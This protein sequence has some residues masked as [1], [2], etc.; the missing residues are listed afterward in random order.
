V[1]NSSWKPA[2]PGHSKRIHS[3]TQNISILILSCHWGQGLWTSVLVNNLWRDFSRSKRTYNSLPLL[4]SYHKM[5]HLHVLFFGVKLIN[6]K[7]YIINLCSTCPDSRSS[8]GRHLHFL[9]LRH[10]APLQRPYLL[11]GRH[12]V[13]TRTTE[14]VEWPHFLLTSLTSWL[15][16]LH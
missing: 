14:A 9:R 7:E 1:T 2:I 10:H 6:L 12:S 15:V 13:T 5:Q 8:F 3:N 16:G 11:T 4:R